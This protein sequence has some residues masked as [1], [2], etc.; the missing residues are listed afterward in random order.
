MSAKRKLNERL[1]ATLAPG[2]SV[3]LTTVAQLKGGAKKRLARNLVRGTAMTLV[4][5]AAT[6]GAAGFFV[7]KLPPAVWVVV[8]SERLLLIARTN[9]GLGDTVFDAPLGALTGTLKSRLLNE[10]TISDAED[11]VSLLRLNLGV[12]KGPATGIV[13]AIGNRPGRMPTFSG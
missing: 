9:S 6:G 10:V 2:E 8:T 12:K 3:V 13:A 11:G 1:S 4:T 5:T 7:T